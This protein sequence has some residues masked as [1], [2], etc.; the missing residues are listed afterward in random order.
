[1]V[2]PTSPNDMLGPFEKH[3]G[4][5]GVNVAVAVDGSRISDKAAMTAGARSGAAATAAAAAV[6]AAAAA[7]A[8]A[9][10]ARLS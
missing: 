3:F 4:G 9:A 7:A 5:A 1:M 8:A 2:N 10:S 6:A